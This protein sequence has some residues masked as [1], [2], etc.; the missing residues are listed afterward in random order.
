MKLILLALVTLFVSCTTSGSH[1]VKLEHGEKIVCKKV[2]IEKCGMNLS[3]CGDSKS[4]EFECAK[5]V[6][7]ISPGEFIEPEIYDEPSKAA[8]PVPSKEV[9]K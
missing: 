5:N 3:G 6:L 9:K 8:T 4:V 7:Y 2:S 1:I